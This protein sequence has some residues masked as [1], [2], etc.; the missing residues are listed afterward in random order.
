MNSDEAS[1]STEAF[2]KYLKAGG[3]FFKAFCDLRDELD[4]Y[5]N[6][7][8]DDIEVEIGSFLMCSFTERFEHLASAA[9]SVTQGLGEINEQ[10]EESKQPRN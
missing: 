7:W 6:A 4:R 2:R 10:I 5:M 1:A 9:Q 8:G 3:D